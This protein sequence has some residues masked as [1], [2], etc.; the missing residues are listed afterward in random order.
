MAGH[1]SPKGVKQGGRK[2]GT[3]N[4]MTGALKEMILGALEE[5]G[6]QKYL[7]SC[8]K[9]NPA[10][11][12]VLLGKVLPTTLVGDANQPIVYKEKSSIGDYKKQF[13]DLASAIAAFEAR[14]QEKK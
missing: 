12:M 9:K 2:K 7:L 3:P 13:P 5:A 11:F 10:A 8:A 14:L 1:G 4:K 6:G